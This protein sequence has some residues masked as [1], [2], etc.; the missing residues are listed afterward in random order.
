MKYIFYI[1]SFIYSTHGLKIPSTSN[2][3]KIIPKYDKIISYIDI[4]RPQN[5]APSIILTMGGE[6]ASLGGGF[7]TDFFTH[8]SL[9]TTSITVGICSTSMILNDYFDAKL[10]TD[11]P[12]INNNNPIV[13]GKLSPYEVKQFL[14]ILYPFIVFAISTID[15]NSLRILFL[16][17]LITTYIY[18]ESLKPYTW[19]KNIS[20]ASITTL[21]PI[22]GGISIYGNAYDAFTFPESHLMGLSIATFMGILHREILMDITDHETDKNNDIITIPVKY[23]NEYAVLISSIALIISGFSCIIYS[24]TIWLGEIAIFIML[25]NLY[26]TWYVINN[27]YI[28]EKE[29]KKAIDESI[30]TFPLIVLSF[31]I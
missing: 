29:C 10:G 4:C 3:Q 2:I 23:G 25:K 9:L 13:S 22:V 6:S 5:I 27:G 11:I 19:I 17:G 30:F 15:I 1:L 16:S 7:P 14:S 21:A 24:K 12:G 20:V 18:T 31:C 28:G 26:E 8:N